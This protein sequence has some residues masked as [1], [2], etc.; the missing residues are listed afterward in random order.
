[1]I[2]SLHK[3]TDIHFVKLFDI[4]ISY[5]TCVYVLY[6]CARV[7]RISVQNNRTFVIEW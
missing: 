1:M 6:M 5:Y 3:E 7:W 4:W 2:V